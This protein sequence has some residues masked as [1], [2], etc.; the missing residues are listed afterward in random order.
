MLAYAMSALIFLLPIVVSIVIGIDSLRSGP[1]SASEIVRTSLCLGGLLLFFLLFVILF[2]SEFRKWLPTR[3]HKLKI[4][5]NGFTYER[6]KRVEVCLWNEIRDINFRMID[7]VSKTSRGRVSVIQSV[8]RRDG[9]VISFAD[10][11]KLKS[12]TT[13]IKAAKSGAA[14]KA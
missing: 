12:I 1:T 14:R 13:T 6:D 11:L 7:Q 5:D 9:A 8:I 10:T 4:Y 3:N 2:R